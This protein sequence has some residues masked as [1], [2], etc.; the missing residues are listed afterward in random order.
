MTY[1]MYPSLPLIWLLWEIPWQPK[2]G[3]HVIVV[4]AV[5]LQGNVQDPTIADPVPNG[6]SGYHTITVTAL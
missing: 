3:S 4:H 6:S 5:D 2:T 1:S